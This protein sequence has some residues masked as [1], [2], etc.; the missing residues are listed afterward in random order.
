MGCDRAA[1]GIWEVWGSVGRGSRAHKE[2]MMSSKAPVV[3]ELGVFCWK[4]T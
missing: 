3:Y 1:G 2:E 4:K